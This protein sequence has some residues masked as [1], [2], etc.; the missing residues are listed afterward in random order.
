MGAPDC[1]EIEL[2]KLP[3]TTGAPGRVSWTNVIPAR[4]SARVWA[5][6]PAT[7]TGRIAPA[8]HRSPL[9][10]AALLAASPAQARPGHP[11][12]AFFYGKS[13]PVAE[14]SH[15]DWVVVEPGHLDARGLA[16]LQRAGVEVFGY[17]SLG[18]A[19]PGEVDPGWVLG[20]NA[21]WGTVILNPAPGFWTMFSGKFLTCISSAR[22]VADEVRQ[23]LQ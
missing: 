2:A 1:I 8:C 22:K 14:L 11:S 3:S 5:Q 15:F 18:E 12:V 16:D 13:V 7:V 23:H 4:A 20:R 21:A 19:A 9:L 10:L 17:L 6:V